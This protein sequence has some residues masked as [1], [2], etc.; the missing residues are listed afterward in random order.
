LKQR[1]YKYL[2]Y[3]LKI[4]D[5]V[6]TTVWSDSSRTYW[7]HYIM[8]TFYCDKNNFLIFRDIQE[9][10]LPESTNEYGEKIKTNKTMFWIRE[11]RFQT[12][13]LDKKESTF[14]L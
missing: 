3:T 6:E 1:L 7:G 5:G 14:D 4:N 13:V 2:S 12:N 8:G 10:T 11:M 9:I